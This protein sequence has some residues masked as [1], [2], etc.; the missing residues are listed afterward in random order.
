MAENLSLVTDHSPTPNEL[1]TF[2]ELDQL[3]SF[4]SGVYP[5][6]DR[7]RFRGASFMKEPIPDLTNVGQESIADHMWA[8]LLMWDALYPLL[9]AF[10]Q[11][12]NPAR[13]SSYILT[14]DMGEI[15]DG[16]ISATLQL[17]GYG[18]NRAEIELVNFKRL[19]SLLPQASQTIFD[20]THLRYEEEKSNPETNDKEVLIAKIMDSVQ[21]DHFVLDQSIDFNGSLEIHKK[22]LARSLMPYVQ[23]LSAILQKEGELLAAEEIRIL[24]KHHL[25][26]YQK[27]GV[28]IIF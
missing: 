22:I 23:R 7:M 11:T 25:H 28:H 13:V 21:G 27:R 12:I 20:Q 3:Y 26:E 19:T 1:T 18:K 6:Y 2:Q 10:S 5:A 14:H 9:P 8:T 15:A 17:D 24:I 4:M 16:D